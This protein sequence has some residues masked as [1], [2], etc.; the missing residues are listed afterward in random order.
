MEQFGKYWTVLRCLPIEILDVY[1]LVVH[2]EA[3]CLEVTV[4]VIL[5][6]HWSTEPEFGQ[7]FYPVDHRPILPCLRAF[8]EIQATQLKRTKDLVL[9]RTKMW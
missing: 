2:V 3:K 1:L 9:L 7:M 4:R 5:M 8:N 6:T